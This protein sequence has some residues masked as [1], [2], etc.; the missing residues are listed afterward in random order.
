MRSSVSPSRVTEAIADRTSSASRGPSSSDS[1]VAAMR[2]TTS[3]ES[4]SSSEM[5]GSAR[6]GMRTPRL[7]QL[8]DLGR[9]DVGAQA[10]A[11]VDRGGLAQR[12]DR[13]AEHDVVGD[14]D[15]VLALGEGHVEQAERG[16]GALDLAGEAAALEADAVADAERARGD[17]HHAGDQVAERLLG[18]EAEDDRGDGATDGQRARV[19]PGDPQRGQRR[20]GEERQADEE[21]DR[22]RGA[23]VDA[24][25]E[26]GSTQRPRSR[27]SAQPS[28]TSTTA[29]A[30]RTGVSTPKIC[31][32]K[33][34]ATIVAR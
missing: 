4:I 26:P 19:E 6:T 21:A 30:T 22:A 17:Q 18:G 7:E 14:H 32:R 1:G 3:S 5:C 25:E 28:T 23:G 29:A 9:L 10:G 12:D 15:R 31:S 20:E 2:T 16:D 33:T 13:G 27:A 8:L 34:Y 11:Q 24:A